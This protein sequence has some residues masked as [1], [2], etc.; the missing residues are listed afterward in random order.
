MPVRKIGTSLFL[1][2]ALV[3]GAVSQDAVPRNVVGGQPASLAEQLKQHHIELTEAGLLKAL[4]SPDGQV[5]YL[6][7]LRL[8]EDSDME[9]VPAIEKALTAE[10]T[11]ETRINIA[12]ALVQLGQDKGLLELAGDCKDPGLP[13]YFR[14]RAMIYM[15]PRGDKACFRAALDLL[16]SDP[17]SRGQVLSLLPQYQNPSKEEADEIVEVTAKCLDD[18]SAAVRIQASITL[19]TLANPSAIGDLQRAIAAEGD[20]IVRSQMQRS[21]QQLHR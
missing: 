20:D 18:E 2:S 6:A 3:I 16:R 11:P 15:L 12:V 7:A 5:R 14:A 9:A 13:G 21:L 4:R 10:K 19:G 8:A 17:D 1:F